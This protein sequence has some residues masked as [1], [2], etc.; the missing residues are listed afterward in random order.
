MNLFNKFGSLLRRKNSATN[1]FL[2]MFIPSGMSASKDAREF[3]FAQEGYSQTVVVYACIREIAVAFSGIKWCLF[4]DVAGVKTEVLEHPILKLWKRPNK[5]QGS[6]TFLLSVASHYSIAGNSYV[7]A[8]TDSRNVPQYLYCLRPDRMS[9][10]P[11]VIDRIAGYEFKVGSQSKKWLDGEILHFKDFHPT[12]DWYGLSPIAVA[13]LSIDS[14]KGQ[15]KWNRNLLENSANPSGILSYEDDL[16]PGV[17]DTIKESFRA[18]FLG[19]QNAGEPFISEGGKMKW[20]T[21]GLNAKELDYI[22]SQKLSALQ[23]AQVF[24]VPPELIGLTPATYQNRREARK[25]LYT[26]V[27]L[28]MLDR[29]RDDLNN[30]LPPM[31][32][33]SSLYFEPDLDDV[34]SLQEDRTA[35]WTRLDT[36]EELTINEKRVA[37]G[38]DERDDGDVILINAGK[39]TLDD[40]VSGSPFDSLPPVEDVPAEPDDDEKSVFDGV[41]TKQARANRNE[42]LSIGRMRK[43]FDRRMAT[44]V[45]AIFKKELSAILDAIERHGD[46]AGANIDEIIDSFKNDWENMVVKNR[47]II[48]DA[49]GKRSL[50]AFKSE[51]PDIEIKASKEDIFQNQIRLASRLYVAEMVTNISTTTKKRIKNVIA[52]GAAEGASIGQ[53]TQSV[54]DTYKGF[55]KARANTIALTETVT[56]QNRGSLEAMGTLDVPLLKV[57][58]WSGITGENERVGHHSADGQSVKQDDAFRVSPDGGSYESLQHPGDPF[59]S[60]GNRIN[61]HCAMTYRRDTENDDR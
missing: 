4:R 3:D 11:D 17:V 30:W 50:R 38:Y 59:A 5:D 12:N 6:A 40:I 61:C 45:K 10:I 47:L 56:A 37:K 58:A 57:W 29:F 27:V 43:K 44:Q 51:N 26:E 46:Q 32:G 8:V 52:D 41:D 1:R 21:I 15:Q 42:V 28:P 16:A 18:K 35:L 34:E 19:P 49:F 31:F 53:L 24:N 36:S 9:V 20:E 60:A 54:Q 33:D 55:S 22:E 25:A 2:T 39:I 23:I 48:M 7:E 13:A 14:F